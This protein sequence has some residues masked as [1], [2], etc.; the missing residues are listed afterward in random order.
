MCCSASAFIR[1]FDDVSVSIEVVI[2]EVGKDKS[3]SL[4]DNGV[5]VIRS[6]IV[7]NDS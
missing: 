1:L 2:D 7:G 4:Y 5:I 6:K 3:I